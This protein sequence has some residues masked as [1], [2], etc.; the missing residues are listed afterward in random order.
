MHVL[1]LTIDL[2]SNA[3][4]RTYALWLL[5]DALGWRTTVVAPR[6]GETWTPVAG[7][8]FAK[9]CVRLGDGAVDWNS[10]VGL[11]RE[12]DLII[13]VKPLEG[14]YG[15]ALR[16]RAQVGTPVLLDIDDPTLEARLSLH[17][18]LMLMAK[19]VL[20]ARMFW[21]SVR[22]YRAAKREQHV[23]TSNPVLQWRWGGDIIP[24]ARRDSGAGL[25]HT[26]G[27]PRVVF[28]GTN[29][30]HK[31]VEELR[32]AIG[33]LQHRGVTLTVTDDPPPDARAWERWVGRTS[34]EQGLELVR[35][36]DVVVLASIPGSEFAEAQLPA[37]LI[38]AM[39]AGRAIVVSDHRPLTWALGGT[40]IVAGSHRA[41]DLAEAIEV[42]CDPMA[43]AAMGTAARSRALEMFSIQSLTGP[44][45]E[46]VLRAVGEQPLPRTGRES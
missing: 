33:A 41:V 4:G 16:L 10:L 1:F 45:A 28:V 17:R 40:G 12:V 42:L 27:Q 46:A 23:L 39:I 14:S 13:A 25:P 22:L 20:R 5:A 15:R 44:F 37:K 36:G 26:S 21:S 29:H 43:R 3:T 6:G 2:Q 24:H 38:D 31:G 34:L 8:D 9:E 7:T 30:R 18:P 32:G 19:S 35:Q 11:A